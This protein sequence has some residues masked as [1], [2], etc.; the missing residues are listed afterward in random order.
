MTTC[1]LIVS[2]L[3]TAEA[4]TDGMNEILVTPV[5]SRN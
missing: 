2:L 5:H 3:M 4:V 1:V